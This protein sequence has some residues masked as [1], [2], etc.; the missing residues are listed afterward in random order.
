MTVMYILGALALVLAAIFIVV[1][2]TKGGL[3]GVY[4]KTIAS[5]GFMALGVFG[6]TQNTTTTAALFI[7]MGML[8]GLIGDIVLDLKVVYK[9][10]NSVTDAE[11]LTD[12]DELQV[13]FF[14]GKAE[15]KVLKINLEWFYEWYA[16]FI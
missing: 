16:R 6:L 1:R 4:T 8:F 9:N 3:L 7:I 11:V 15:V 12:G 5:V 2:V 14:K 10:D 13:R